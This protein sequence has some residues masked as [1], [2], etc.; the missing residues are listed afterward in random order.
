MRRSTPGTRLAGAAMSVLLAG[1]WVGASG[2]AFPVV[3]NAQGPQAVTDADVIM[4][5][6][7]PLEHRGVTPDVVLV[8]SEADLAAGRDPVLAAALLRFGVVVDPVAAGRALNA[9]P[10]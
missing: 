10:K 2:P 8:P 1:W 7:Q 5:D 4:S 6:G 9:P 3:L